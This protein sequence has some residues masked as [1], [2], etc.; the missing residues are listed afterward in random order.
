MLNF[1]VYFDRKY[2]TIGMCPIP[3]QSY[4]SNLLEVMNC[5]GQLIE[6]FLSWRS[7]D[8]ELM[9]ELQIYINMIILT[10][11]SRE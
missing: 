9:N 8:S 3:S 5:R 7:Y 4:Y 1:I 2:T 10:I 11:L 6:R